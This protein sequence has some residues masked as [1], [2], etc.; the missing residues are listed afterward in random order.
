MNSKFAC[1]HCG[2]SHPSEARFCPVTGQP[3]TDSAECP[4]CGKRALLGWRQCPNCGLQL[5]GEAQRAAAEPAAEPA[6]SGLPQP[7]QRRWAAAGIALAAACAANV[8]AVVLCVAVANIWVAW[9]WKLS[10]GIER[11]SAVTSAVS[12]EIPTGVANE[13]GM[14]NTETPAPSATSM[15]TP[16]STPIRTPSPIPFRAPTQL[17]LPTN[18]QGPPPLTAAQ[19]AQFLGPL[20]LK[21]TFVGYQSIGGGQCNVQFFLDAEGGYGYYSYYVDY[22]SEKPEFKLV[23]R[24]Y[25][26]YLATIQRPNGWG[27]PHSFIVW[28]GLPTGFGPEARRASVDVYV[29]PRLTCP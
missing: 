12:T 22:D 20:T 19:P 2:G 29:D 26:D 25:G 16:N 8:I 3:L 14:T 17:S 4:R 7:V 28:S 10:R 15:R 18:T 13:N 6:R 21:A 9:I 5:V 27:G 11:A 1:S 24:H 23:D